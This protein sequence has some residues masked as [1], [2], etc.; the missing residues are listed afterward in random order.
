MTLLLEWQMENSDTAETSAGD[1]A[2]SR[3]GTTAFDA[4][5]KHDGSYSLKCT[6]EGNAVFDIATLDIA[7][8]TGSLV[9][10]VYF[11]VL[12]AADYVFE[13]KLG[14]DNNSLGLIVWN[15]GAGDYYLYAAYYGDSTP[16]SVTPAGPSA[17]VTGQWYKVT[18][19]WRTGST[20][21]S[22][23]LQLDSGIALTNGTELTAWATDSGQIIIG[24]QGAGNTTYFD[25]LQIWDSWDG[26]E[27]GAP[28]AGGM[29]SLLNGLIDGI[30]ELIV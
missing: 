28:P 11:A 27:G 23:S 8:N 12:A 6:G 3:S 15:N 21:P 2:A 30:G 9:F 20:L 14:S 13:I 17:V 29:G 1:T 10:Y 19:R 24:N 26:P 18:L 5:I 16:L 4:T 7:K 25:N 22:L